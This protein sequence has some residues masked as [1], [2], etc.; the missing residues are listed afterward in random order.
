MH[1]SVGR[2]GRILPRLWGVCHPSLTIGAE[3]YR[4]INPEDK[5][6]ATP[7]ESIFSEPQRMPQSKC[8]P[9]PCQF[10]QNR[11]RDAA[12]A[13][14]HPKRTF[15]CLHMNVPHYTTNDP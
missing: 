15:S 2:F 6:E 3:H 11:T 12:R 7:G 9:E 10:C 5:G 13:A 8:V 1:V 14:T 4:V